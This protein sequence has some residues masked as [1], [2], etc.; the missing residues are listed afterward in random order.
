MGVSG[1]SF[2]AGVCQFDGVP[3]IS[4]L[5]HFDEVAAFEESGRASVWTAYLDSA[6]LLGTNQYAPHGG[7]HALH[8]HFLGWCH[9]CLILHLEATDSARSR[10]GSS[11]SGRRG[12][13]GTGSNGRRAYYIP[14][15]TVVPNIPAAI[16]HAR[17][18]ALAGKESVVTAEA[19]AAAV[20]LTYPL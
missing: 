12:R 14:T 13:G 3:A 5:A 10:W 15:M 11:S 7:R 18:G 16:E 1:D 20:R 8:F 17:A 9:V 6:C 2:S 4:L 19:Y